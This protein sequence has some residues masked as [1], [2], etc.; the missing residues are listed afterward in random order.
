[1]IQVAM[2]QDLEAGCKMQEFIG[3]YSSPLNA[4]QEP[5]NDSDFASRGLFI[6]I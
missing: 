5:E 4:G 6:V 2:P 3:E 1:M